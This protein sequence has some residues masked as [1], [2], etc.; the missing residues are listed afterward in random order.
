MQNDTLM[1]NEIINPWPDIKF[2]HCY[3]MYE[4]TGSR[5]IGDGRLL[6]LRSVLVIVSVKLC[7]DHSI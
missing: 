1:R 4:G 6:Q 2:E 5:E 3:F 7:L